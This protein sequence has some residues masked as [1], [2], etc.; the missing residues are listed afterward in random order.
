MHQELRN[1]LICPTLTKQQAWQQSQNIT[2]KS[3]V[4]KRSQNLEENV[5][6]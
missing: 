5:R 4:Y 1:L 6:M 3:D 2:Q